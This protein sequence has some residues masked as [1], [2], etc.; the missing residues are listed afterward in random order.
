MTQINKL[1]EKKISLKK[2]PNQ[3]FAEKFCQVKKN[4]AN[5]ISPKKKSFKNI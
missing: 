1:S 4:F 3:I 5:K 2:F